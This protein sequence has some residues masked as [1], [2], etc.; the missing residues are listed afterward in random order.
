MKLGRKLTYARQHIESILRHDAEPIEARREAARLLTEH[1][2]AELA[3][4][5][6]R[7][8]EQV[9]QALADDPKE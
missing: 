2:T 7:H 1:V 8:A 4:A 9:A 5:E 3:A 6:E